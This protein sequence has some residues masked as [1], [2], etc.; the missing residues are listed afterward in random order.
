MWKCF[1]SLHVWLDLNKG[2]F[3]SSKSPLLIYISDFVVSTYFHVS[4]YHK[5]KERKDDLES[6]PDSGKEPVDYFKC[7]NPGSLDNELAD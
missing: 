5:G 7:Q 1:F 3:L 4:I 6:L 2:C